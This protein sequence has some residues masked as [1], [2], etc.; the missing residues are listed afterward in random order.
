M[1]NLLDYEGNNC[2]LLSERA[3]RTFQP[4]KRRELEESYKLIVV[5]IDL[6]EHI[7]GGSA[8]CMV[9]EMF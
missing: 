7:G 8:R 2:I 3:R 5:N 6:I 9:A 1:F 4:D